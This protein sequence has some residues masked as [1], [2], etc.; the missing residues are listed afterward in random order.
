MKSKILKTIGVV[1]IISSFLFFSR[2]AS[3]QQ[4]YKEI[5]KRN[6]VR[7]ENKLTQANFYT[8]LG[9]VMI[10]SGVVFIAIG[11]KRKEK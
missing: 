5:A 10:I 2:I 3:L 1:L 4:Q 7:A 11:K 6:E 9:V 8:G